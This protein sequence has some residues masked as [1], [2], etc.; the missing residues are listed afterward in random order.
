MK[1]LIIKQ[2]M[3]GDVLISSILCNNLKKA[4]PDSQ[5]DYLVYESTVGVLQGNPNIDNIIY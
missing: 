4:Y 5:V 3:I 2:K 1:I